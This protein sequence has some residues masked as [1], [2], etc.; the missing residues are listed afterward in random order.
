MQYFGSEDNI[1]KSARLGD[2]K[3]QSVSDL[4]ASEVA[5]EDRE[6]GEWNSDTGG[7][8]D[9]EHREASEFEGN[10]HFWSTNVESQEIIDV[11]GTS[12]CE[13]ISDEEEE[14]PSDYFDDSVKACQYCGGWDEGR[15]VIVLRCGLCPKGGGRYPHMKSKNS[16]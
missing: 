1:A 7:D 16:Q 15:T 8:L 3:F 5:S 9:G 10:S 2:K 6:S 14:E 13:E 4:E 11:S 12:S